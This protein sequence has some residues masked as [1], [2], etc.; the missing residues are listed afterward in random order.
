MHQIPKKIKTEYHD[1]SYNPITQRT[2]GLLKK[3]LFLSKVK[4]WGL[5]LEKRGS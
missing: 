1:T 4:I 5:F 2:A 3:V